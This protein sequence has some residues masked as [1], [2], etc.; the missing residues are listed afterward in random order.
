MSLI[1][2]QIKSPHALRADPY[3]KKSPPRGSDLQ[4]LSDLRENYFSA[5]TQ[6][7]TCASTSL[8]TLMVTVNTPTCLIGSARST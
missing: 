6:T 7:L 1:V 4:F 3:V 5:T 8:N 2:M